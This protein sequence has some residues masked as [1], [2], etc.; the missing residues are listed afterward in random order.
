[1]R[2]AR[3]GRHELVSAALAGCEDGELAARL[4]AASIRAVGVGGGASVLDVD[5]TPV[6]VKQ[7]PITER[8]LAHPYSTANLFDLPVFCQ[9]G[10]YRLGSPGF[11][12]WRE[13]AA[14]RM[15]TEAVLGGEAESFPLLHHWRVLPGRPP[16]AAEH[17]DVDAVVAQFG[18]DS[19]VRTRLEESAVAGSSLVL[20]LEYVPCSLLDRLNDPVS[21][22]E[23]VER[24]LFEIVSCLQTRA[25][26]HMDGHVG[27]LRSDGDRIYLVDVGLA[28]SPSFELSSSERD[29]AAHHAGHDGDYAAMQLV[30]W[31][32]TTVCG[33]PTPTHGGPIDR[34]AYVA[35]CASG[36]IPR[37]VP[38]AVASILLRHAPAAARMNDFHW[39]LYDGDL[40]ASYPCG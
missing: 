36:D 26:L 19:T 28:T 20:F 7:M 21:Q 2:T 33:V 27:N 34:N 15:V 14:N 32:V 16:V 39:R 6:F 24:Q 13:L 12:V 29:F 38:A 4:G 18:G 17:Q 5:G 11:G 10:M 31:L 35:R 3:C 23:G 22:A 37:D 8:E 9:Y 40:R 25:V 1:V 30:N